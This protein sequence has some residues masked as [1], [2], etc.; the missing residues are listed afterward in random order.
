MLKI[1]GKKLRKKLGTEEKEVKEEGQEQ[2][3]EQK[4]SPT[5]STE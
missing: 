2:T 5:S 4:L 3:S 1:N